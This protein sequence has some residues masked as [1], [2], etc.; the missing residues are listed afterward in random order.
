MKKNILIFG[1][2]ALLLVTSLTFVGINAYA[3]IPREGDNAIKAIESLFGEKKDIQII[4]SAIYE[5][6]LSEPLIAL[7][8]GGYVYLLEAKSY[9]LKAIVIQEDTNEKLVDQMDS[10]ASAEKAAVAFA[11]RVTPDFFKY[12]DVFCTEYG[13]DI[14]DIYS[15]EIW[16]KVNEE[17][18]TGNKIAMIVR[19]DGTLN[20]YVSVKGYPL[21]KDADY[22][23]IPIITEQEAIEIAY[24]SL[25]DTVYE[26][27]NKE[28]NDSNTIEKVINEPIISD[29][30][31]LIEEDLE[32]KLPAYE[33][34]LDDKNSH[35][36]DIYKQINNGSILYYITIKNV[37]TN[38]IWDMGFY[39]VVDAVSGE[40]VSVDYTR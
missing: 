23:R 5:E 34:Y 24:S 25:K 39:V 14:Y 1:G 15:V 16:E 27:E 10:I 9:D 22:S 33:I 26:L 8:S 3:S 20:S 6:A 38:R 4:D 2:I 29:S 12:Y 31:E 35:S 17:I 36:V 13:E 32:E 40:V 19:P 18:Y 21:D 28:W 11:Q 37:K 30:G 7:K